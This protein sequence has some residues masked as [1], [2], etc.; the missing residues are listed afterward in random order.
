MRAGRGVRAGWGVPG[1]LVMAALAAPMV[2]WW[3]PSREAMPPKKSGPPEASTS[4]MPVSLRS[5]RR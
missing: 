5:E 4:C 1:R 3:A 2:V